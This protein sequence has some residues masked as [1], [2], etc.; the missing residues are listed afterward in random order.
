MIYEKILTSLSC[1]PIRI[2]RFFIMFRLAP[3]ALTPYDFN[4][5]IRTVKMQII[6]M[7]KYYKK[8]SPLTSLEK[9]FVKQRRRMLTILFSILI[10][11]ESE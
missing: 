8:P 10:A 7:L 5:Q 9:A 6:T 11:T 1:S 4:K 2:F 3:N